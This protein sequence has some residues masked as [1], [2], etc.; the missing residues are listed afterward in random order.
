[1]KRAGAGVS[2]AWTKDRMD[3]IRAVV[4]KDAMRLA[5]PWETPDCDTPQNLSSEHAAI[6]D[7]AL[8]SEPLFQVPVVFFTKTGSDF[9]F[10]DDESVF[11]KVLCLHSG[12]DLTDLN[13]DGRNWAAEEKVTLKRPATLIDCLSMVERGEADALV[14]SEAESRF[15]IGRLGLS[16]SFRMAERPLST[17]GIHI[18]LTKNRPGA[19]ELLQKLNEAIAELKKSGDYSAIIAR[20]LP[21][22]MPNTVAKVQCGAYRCLTQRK[23]AGSASS[24]ASAAPAMLL[25]SALAFSSRLWRIADKILWTA[26]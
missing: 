4:S 9:E 20:H 25:V 17:R 8:V 15:A 3:Q 10:K 12:R 18:I 2:L 7:G 26:P 19:E 16:E 23:A 11:G 22:F 14:G 6:C 1:M 13:R 21:A 24:K 5:A